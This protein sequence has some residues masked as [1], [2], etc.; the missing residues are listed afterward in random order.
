MRIIVCLLV[1][2]GSILVG[3]VAPAP[4]QDKIKLIFIGP[5]GKAIEPGNLQIPGLKFKLSAPPAAK[6]DNADEQLQKVI[7]SL[8]EIRDNL[9]K[10][11]MPKAPA[12]QAIPFNFGNIQIELKFDGKEKNIL[13]DGLLKELMKK[14]LMRLDFK[15][16]KPA[17]NG[18][19]PAP[20][21]GKE[22][23]KILMK[24]RRNDEPSLADLSK[25]MDRILKDVEELRRDVDRLK[26]SGNE[27]R[28]LRRKEAGAPKNDPGIDFEASRA[29]ARRSEEAAR[30]ALAQA[31]AQAAA[32]ERAALEARQQADMARAAEAKAQQDA[33]RRSGRKSNED[34]ERAIQRILEDLEALRQEMREKKK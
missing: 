30:A 32:L 14:G 17:E 1:A 19:Q 12:G 6:P 25:K 20:Q 22:L 24:I 31:K 26:Q 18:A 33:Q 4:A 16:P 5:D 13:V 2:A 3:P 7:Q 27:R 28:P 21:G 9:Q 34:Y 29:E 15:E 10:E 23:P 11:K 8:K